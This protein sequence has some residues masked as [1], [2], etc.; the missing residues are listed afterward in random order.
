MAK[1]KCVRYVSVDFFGKLN[2]REIN[3]PLYTYI[4]DR[5]DTVYDLIQGMND[6]H[7]AFAPDGYKLSRIWVKPLMS[8]DNKLD[9]NDPQ[10]FVKYTSTRKGSLG[11]LWSESA[12]LSQK[13]KD[14]NCGIDPVLEKKYNEHQKTTGKKHIDV[15]RREAKEEIKKNKF[16][17]VDI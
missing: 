13:R 3:I 2:Q 12:E 5:N 11:D 7:E 4:D 9:E 10:S 6:L 16:F 17:D 14:K 15:K 8:V 1:R